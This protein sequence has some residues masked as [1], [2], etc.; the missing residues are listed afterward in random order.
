MIIIICGDTIEHSNL[1]ILRKL[2][3]SELPHYILN[4]NKLYNG[5][6]ELNLSKDKCELNGTDLIHT[7]KK[8]TVVLF[9]GWTDV[10]NIIDEMFISKSILSPILF[11]KIKE[12]IKEEI[13][14]ITRYLFSLIPKEATWFPCRN[15]YLSKIEQ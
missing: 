2:E 14:V 7:F 1:Y 4:P 13:R 10:D 15:F 12:N 9:L 5:K 6:F 8:A 11:Y 3:R